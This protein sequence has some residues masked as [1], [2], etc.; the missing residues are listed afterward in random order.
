MPHKRNPI[1]TENL[2]GCARLL[3]S[4]ASAALENIAL[5]HERDIS[6]SAV[7]RIV[8]PD[9]MILLDYALDRMNSVLE[10][11]VIRR[12]RVLHNLSLAGSTVFSGHYLLALVK[13]GATR[14]DAYGWVQECALAS[15]EGRGNFIDLLKAHTEVSRI[16]T[17]KEIG[18]LG[19]IEYQLRN[20]SEIF[21]RVSEAR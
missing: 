17:V 10:G 19:S 16:L 15:L 7:E 9:S 2:T 18:R 11:L 8:F 14:E 6:H 3:R 5:W 4:Y 20:V 12:D 13:N 1:S 21:R